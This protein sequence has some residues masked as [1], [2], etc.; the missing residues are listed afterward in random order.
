[1]FEQPGWTRKSD[2]GVDLKYSREENPTVRALEKVVSKLESAED[3]L[4]FSSGMA[5]IASIYL[6]YMRSGDKLVLPM[7]AY[8]ATL[9]LAQDLSRFGVKP[10]F[11]WP[12]A[13]EIVEEIDEKVRLV[14][15][16][17]MTNPMLRVIDVPEISKRCREVGA[18]LV[19]DNTFVTPVLYK[20]LMDGV[21]LVL[22]S[23]TKYLSGH[24]DVVSGVVAGGREE[25][26][27]LWDW[28][29][30]LGTI[31]APIEAY[32][33]L[34]GL[35]T[36]E[37]RVKRQCESAMIIAEFLKEHSRV[38][39]VHYPGLPD[40][41]GHKVA[42]KLF[43]NGFGGVLSF[44]IKGGRREVISLMKSLKVIKPAP[45]LGGAESLLAYPIISAAMTI[46]EEVRRRL[47]ITEDLLRLSIGLEDVED[48][49]EDLDHALKEI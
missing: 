32:L 21:D 4:C 16:E 33:V 37:L 30:K 26:K 3:S 42:K 9:Q 20:P 48:L 43:K 45:S 39:R 14:L 8:G 11:A 49:I 36:L 5:A 18:I 6:A 13:E 19:A 25:I 28:R 10:V 12:R 41:E 46:P 15:V 23:A 17:T 24:N 35:K 7:E 34:R 47:G 2:R 40:D 38:K 29:R 44:R 27:R 22:H 31:L 1:M